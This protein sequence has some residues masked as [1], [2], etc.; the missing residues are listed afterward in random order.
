MVIHVLN[1][2]Y[3]NVQCT[4]IMKK[5]LLYRSSG[6]HR[7]CII[8]PLPQKQDP[9]QF[10]TSSVRFNLYSAIW[11]HWTSP[12]EGDP[13]ACSPFRV[14]AGSSRPYRWTDEICNQQ[15]WFREF[16]LSKRC[17]CLPASDVGRVRIPGSGV[18][19][20]E[21]QGLHTEAE[22]AKSR[23]SICYTLQIRGSEI[24][25]HMLKDVFRSVPG[26]ESSY[27]EERDLDEW[28]IINLFPFLLMHFSLWE[29]WYNI[30]LLMS[31]SLQK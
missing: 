16:G 1:S 31:C 29:Y 28:M 11:W 25:K 9:C 17:V 18:Q 21:P 20:N 24:P 3:Y 6:I 8:L 14:H 7:S 13:C 4:F 26:A 5:K 2:D 30:Q 19:R 10:G 12:R 22:S 27:M 15:C 23:G